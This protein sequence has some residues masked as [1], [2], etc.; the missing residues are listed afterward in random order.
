MPISEKGY[1][2]LGGFKLLT[3]SI[4]SLFV[5]LEELPNPLFEFDFTNLLLTFIN[6]MISVTFFIL[7][8]VYFFLEA[9][10][11]TKKGNKRTLILSSIIT[12]S[13]I[14]VALMVRYAIEFPE[15]ELYDLSSNFNMI[16]SIVSAVLNFLLLI[17]FIRCGQHFAMLRGLPGSSYIRGERAFSN[18]N[19]KLVI[20]PL[21]LFFVWSYIV[22]TI[23][24]AEPTELVYAM[25]PVH[26][27]FNALMYNLLSASIVA[28]LTE[29]IMYRHF[30]MG[31]FY[32]WFGRDKW[33]VI[34][35]IFITSLIFAI[36]HVGVLTID[37]IKLLQIL[38]LGIVFGYLYHKKG[39][40]SAI[41]CHSFFNTITVL[42]SHF[43]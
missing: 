39:L 13:T 36:A 29:E 6:L 28:P 33:A 1:Y 11:N 22:F 5:A 7:A 16:I 12:L 42:I 26:N 31:L 10:V 4:N 24:P 2:I 30:A 35:N 8:I 17:L 20:L 34:L 38:P 40:A 14:A 3:S 18:I 37:F 27:D 15:S 43:A 23:F 32:R 41:L 9:R 21:P 19:W 25:T